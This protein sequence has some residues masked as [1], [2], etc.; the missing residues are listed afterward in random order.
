MTTGKSERPIVIGFSIKRK[1]IPDGT[2]INLMIIETVE[3]QGVLV[4]FFVAQITWLHIYMRVFY[5]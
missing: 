4:I 1:E 5:L 2:R 3:I